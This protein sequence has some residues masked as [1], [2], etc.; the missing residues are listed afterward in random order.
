MAS[1]L[2]PS[3]VALDLEGLLLDGLL[4]LLH[5][6]IELS[7]LVIADEDLSLLGLSHLA[8]LPQLVL[9]EDTEGLEVRDPLLPDL[10]V[11]DM[12]VIVE[13]VLTG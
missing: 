11:V 8:E 12:L 4:V 10:V 3:T 1:R 7:L 6:P 9:L 5:E 2:W 13:L